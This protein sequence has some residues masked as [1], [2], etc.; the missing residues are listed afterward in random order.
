LTKQLLG[1]GGCAEDGQRSNNPLAMAT[2][3]LMQGSDM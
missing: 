2:D 1:S 3:L